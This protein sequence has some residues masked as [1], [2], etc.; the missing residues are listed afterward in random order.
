M[1]KYEAQILVRDRPVRVFKHEGDFFIEGRKGSSFELKFINNTWDR[2]EV[3]I[4]VDGT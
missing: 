4:S 2:I 3:V 1:S